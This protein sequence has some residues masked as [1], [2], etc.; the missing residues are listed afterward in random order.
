MKKEIL[1]SLGMLLCLNSFAQNIRIE[2][3]NIR[4]KDEVVSVAFTIMP[5]KLKSNER[6][7]ITP[8]LFS[9]D[10]KLPLKPIIITGRNRAISDRR[11]GL[12]PGIRTRKNQSVTYNV[13]VPYESWMSDISLRVDRTVENCCIQTG[14][15][16]QA[17]VLNRLI[18]YDVILPEI[19]PVAPLLSPL[20]QLDVRTPFLAPIEQYAMMKDNEDL[21]RAEGALIVRFRQGNMKIDPAFDNNAASLDQVC[22]VFDLISQDPDAS[23]GKIVLAGASSPEGGIKINEQLSQ[24]RVKAL[25]DYLKTRTPININTIESI[26]IGEDWVGLRDM[27]KK[28]DM[29]YK[30]EVLDI[31]DNIPIT[32]G[33]EKQLMDLKWG[34]PYNYMMAHFFPKLR[35]AGY[36]R[37]FYQTKPDME[38]MATNQAIDLCNNKEYQDALTRLEGVQSTAAT[39]YVRGVCHM[40]LG[41]YDKANTALTKASALGNTLADE[42]LKQV[43]K[44]KAVQ[45]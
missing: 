20:E 29:Q 6:L 42:Q 26:V 37:V 3:T 5:E 18:R 38:L 1:L 11:L 15:Y 45:Q 8:T 25:Q 14:L 41:Q 23:I 16:S 27:V 22:R 35:S 30:H 4:E 36:I 32:L 39:E 7:T 33:R 31:I 13:A 21:L 40:M 9:A 2:Q 34:R 43:Y 17:V 12:R 28:S 44:L 24:R 19:E 10:N